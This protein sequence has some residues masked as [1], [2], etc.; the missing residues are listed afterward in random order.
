[1]EAI[2]SHC[3]STLLRS[4]WL[5]SIAKRGYNRITFSGEIVKSISRL[6][7]LQQMIF[8]LRLH[9]TNQPAKTLRSLKQS[10]GKT[11][12]AKIF[13]LFSI[14]ARSV[15]SSEDDS[16]QLFQL[17][18]RFAPWNV[19]MEKLWKQGA[20]RLAWKLTFLFVSAQEWV[21]GQSAT[22]RRNDWF[23]MEV[24]FYRQSKEKV[25]KKNIGNLLSIM[26]LKSWQTRYIVPSTF[27]RDFPTR[28]D[29]LPYWNNNFSAYVPFSS[30]RG[31]WQKANTTD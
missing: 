21:H 16:A 15:V 22:A 11:N 9:P 23:V 14:S 5:K 1:M 18:L 20:P 19:T 26:M 31:K 4:C 24:A 6:M 30:R 17:W 12:A 8:L 25:R 7:M 2:K 28:F 10:N 29:F 3:P 27:R 13:I